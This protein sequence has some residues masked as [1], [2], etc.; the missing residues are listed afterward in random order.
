[1]LSLEHQMPILSPLLPSVFWI[2]NFFK[3]FFYPFS[4]LHQHIFMFYCACG[5]VHI[6]I[7]N[8]WH[9]FNYRMVKPRKKLIL[10]IC[11]G[12]DLNIS[13]LKSVSSRAK[14]KNWTLSSYFL[15]FLLLQHVW[16]ILFSHFLWCSKRLGSI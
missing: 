8:A 4:L 12:K 7:S 9:I 10:N 11:N 1:M 3:L 13:N 16:C 2:K 5:Y 6:S 14:K 15:F